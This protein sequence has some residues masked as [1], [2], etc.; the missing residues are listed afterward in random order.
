[1][2]RMYR[3]ER[4]RISCNGQQMPLLLLHP[5]KNAKPAEQTPGVL[6]LH[7]G[8]YATGMAQMVYFS[9]ALAL[10]EKPY[11]D[12]GRKLRVETDDGLING[13]VVKLPLVKG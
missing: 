9:R 6:W 13:E 7:G 10:V 4:V 11:S 5:V 3:K 1:M 12:A 8:G 2:E